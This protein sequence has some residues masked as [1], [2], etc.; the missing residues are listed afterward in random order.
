MKV[1][2]HE[3]VASAVFG[4]FFGVIGYFVVKRFT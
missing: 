1:G 3:L 2:I 4:A